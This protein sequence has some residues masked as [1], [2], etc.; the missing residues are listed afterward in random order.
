MVVVCCCES[1]GVSTG[2]L[3]KGVF[4]V[5]KA[6]QYKLWHI[7]PTLRSL[8]SI[9]VNAHLLNVNMTRY[10]TRSPSLATH[11]P[12]SAISQAVEVALIDSSTYLKH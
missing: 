10:N 2:Q 4:E 12:L 8:T 6:K 5:G 7:K 11:R 3:M 1:A 9:H